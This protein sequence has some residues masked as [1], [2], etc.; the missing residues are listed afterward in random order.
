MYFHREVLYYSQEGRKMEIFTFSS[1]DGLTNERE[2]QPEAGQGL[3]PESQD[4]RPFKFDG[5]R[6]I[7]FTSRVHPGETPGSHVLNGSLDLLT[8]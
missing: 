1:K 7:F 6:Y 2:E 5:K 4:N 3:Y 8:E